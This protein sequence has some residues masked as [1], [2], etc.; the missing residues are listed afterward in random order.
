MF[1]NPLSHR[2]PF[3][4]FKEQQTE[5]KR[6]LLLIL[7]LGNDYSAIG[8]KNACMFSAYKSLL[9]IKCR[10]AAKLKDSCESK[11]T[12]AVFVTVYYSGA[13]I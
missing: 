6:F 7:G 4:A 1:K 10:N 13:C 9:A 8:I 2:E 5:I 12:Q 3:I 11:K